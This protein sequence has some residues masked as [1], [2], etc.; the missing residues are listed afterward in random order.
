MAKRAVS[1]TL[2][3]ANLTWLKGRVGT[4]AARNLS[5]L[6]DQ[7]VTEARKSGSAGTARSVAGTIEIDSRDPALDTADDAVRSLFAASL[8]RPF[9]VRER[10]PRAAAPRRA[11]RR[12]G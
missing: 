4:G 8:A 5:D 11:P 6:L 7:I 1:V 3:I 10:S 12:R 9:M 2:D